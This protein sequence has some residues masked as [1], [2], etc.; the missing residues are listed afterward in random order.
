MTHLAQ[1]LHKIIGPQFPSPPN[2]FPKLLL[3]VPLLP[4]PRRHDL[5]KFLPPPTTVTP[6]PQFAKQPLHPQPAHPPFRR[7]EVF[8][9]TAPD[10]ILKDLPL[11]QQPRAHRI[12]MHI[13]AYHPQIKIIAPIDQ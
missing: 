7:F 5:P 10:I 6:D 12:Q 8:R 3:R 1:A 2:P 13:V 11:A 9:K 4:A